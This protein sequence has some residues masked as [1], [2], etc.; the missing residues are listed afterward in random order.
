MKKDIIKDGAWTDKAAEKIARSG[1]KVQSKFANGMGRLTG[2]M[3]TRNLKIALVIFCVVVGGYSAY[4]FGDALFSNET[5]STIN[6]QKVTMPKHA[7]Q[8]GD[9]NLLSNQYVDDIT[10]R[11][12]VAFKKYMDS[13]KV[14]RY[15]LYESVMRERPG[16]M[17]SVQILIE[18][19]K[20]Y[21]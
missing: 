19:Y 14:T 11:E 20:E 5:N 2:N 3:S 7:D 12:L 17:D 18:A 6:V 8:A 9:E 16:L 10:Y 15:S 1:L 13:L 21:K 4:I